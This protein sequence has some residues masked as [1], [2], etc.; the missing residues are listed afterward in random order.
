[1]VPARFLYVMLGAR[2]R[3]M[4][5]AQRF[6]WRLVG[7]NHRE[8][9]RSA[10]V[11]ADPG[12]CRAAVLRLRQRVGDA[13]ALLATADAAGGGGWAWRLEIEGR[14]VAV[15]GRTY[16]RQ[17]DCQFNLGQFLHVV[18]VA[19]LAEPA[20]VRSRTGAAARQRVAPGGEP[21][22]RAAV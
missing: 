11:F 20:P 10:Q 4:G 2:Q 21:G 16:Q 9:G 22:D 17:R 19:E 14:P 12:E 3:P 7:A 18:P 15:A 13:R 1:M 8:L 5:E 6:A